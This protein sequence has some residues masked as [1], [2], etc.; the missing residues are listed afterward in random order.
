M[1]ESITEPVPHEVQAGNCDGG[2]LR[3]N[4]GGG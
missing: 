4:N 3:S 1:G 2:G